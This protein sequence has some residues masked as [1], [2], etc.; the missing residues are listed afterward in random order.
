MLKAWPMHIERICPIGQLTG[1]L[2]TCLIY[3]VYIL[4]IPT[5]L[6]VVTI[7]LLNTITNPF[8][9]KK[10]LDIIKIFLYHC[11]LFTR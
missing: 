6:T 11:R 10:N 2:C 5:K 8:K 4:P 9:S 7:I 1:Y 3:T